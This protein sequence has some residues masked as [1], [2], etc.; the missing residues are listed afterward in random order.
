MQCINN[1]RRKTTQFNL[2]VSPEQQEKDSKVADQHTDQVLHHKARWAFR[3]GLASYQDV[4]VANTD[5]GYGID[6]HKTCSTYEVR[7]ATRQKLA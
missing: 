2:P 6:I 5:K 4:E 1:E 3:D 7:Q